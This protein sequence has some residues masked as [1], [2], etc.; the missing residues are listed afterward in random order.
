M[1]EGRRKN[2]KRKVIPLNFYNFT[3]DINYE[4]KQAS[5]IL[6]GIMTNNEQLGIINLR[7]E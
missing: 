3:F 5:I 4:H 7:I 2:G 1:G 6:K